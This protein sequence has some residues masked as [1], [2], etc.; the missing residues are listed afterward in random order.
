MVKNAAW[1]KKDGYVVPRDCY[2]S[3]FYLPE[4]DSVSVIDKFILHGRKY[5][6][7]CDGGSALHC[8]LKEHLSKEQYAHLL[9]V[10]I[11]TG[12]PYFTFNIPNTI[13]N[14]CGHIE[15]H[16]L[17]ACPKC[18]SKDVDFITRCIGYLVRIKSMAAG[19]MEEA[20]K[21]FYA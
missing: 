12:C 6:R 9:R 5:T 2:N 15:K 16:Y 3:Y 1:D 7:Y 13:C 21:R 8:N 18:G 20:K 14:Q 4:D 17:D 10:A 19:R 11:K